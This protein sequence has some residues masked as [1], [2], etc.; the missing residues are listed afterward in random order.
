MSGRLPRVICAIWRLIGRIYS[1]VYLRIDFEWVGW[2]TYRFYIRV[3]YGLINWFIDWLIRRLVGCPIDCLFAR[4]LIVV[5]PRS[6]LRYDIGLRGAV[7]TVW[8]VWIVWVVGIVWSSR[9]RIGRM[10]RMGCQDRMGRRIRTYGPYFPYLH[11]SR[12][13]RRIVG[14]LRDRMGP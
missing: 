8:V 4:F 6:R 7:W 1:W 10:A 2:L 11:G 14:R 9:S 3:V 12:T 5:S 13:K